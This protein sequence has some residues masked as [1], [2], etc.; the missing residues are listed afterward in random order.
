[1]LAACCSFAG[2]CVCCSTLSSVAF[3]HI[4]ITWMKTLCSKCKCTIFGDQGVVWYFS[5]PFFEY[6]ASNA[7]WGS[8][9]PHRLVGFFDFAY[10]SGDRG[11][12][13]TKSKCL[14]AKLCEMGLSAF[15]SDIEFLHITRDY[16]YVAKLILGIIIWSYRPHCP[17]IAFQTAHVISCFWQVAVSGP[18]Q[19]GPLDR[20]PGSASQTQGA[21]QLLQPAARAL[22]PELRQRWPPSTSVHS[23]Q[24]MF[25]EE[26]LAPIQKW[27]FKVFTCHHHSLLVQCKLPL[28]SSDSSMYGFK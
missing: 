11:W 6:N 15:L 27:K 28:S 14:N 9:V 5:L 3:W 4:A 23:E 20:S 1:M 16:A 25:A 7:C 17:S 24:V 19:S 26:L 21:G 2:E 10:C 8:A 12:N 22:P 18:Q 13:L